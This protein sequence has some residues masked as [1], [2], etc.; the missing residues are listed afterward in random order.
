M[1]DAGRLENET[2][3]EGAL[4]QGAQHR[5]LPAAN[6]FS[7][8]IVKLHDLLQL[9]ADTPSDRN[10]QAEQIR[11]A[12]FANKVEKRTDPAGRLKQQLQ[13]SRNVLI[14]VENYLLYDKDTAILTSF[15][16]ELLATT[17][18]AARNAAFARHILTQLHGLEVL[19]IIHAMQRADKAV[20]KASLAEELNRHDFVTTL[21]GPIP[22]NTVNHLRMIAWLREANVVSAKGYV[23]DESV[24][25]TL[26][27]SAIADLEDA[28][29]L[30]DPQKVFLQVIRRDFDVNGAR[31]MFVR[32]V[33]TLCKATAPTLFARTDNLKRAVVEPLVQGRWLGHLTKS[34][35]GRG[36]DSGRVHPLE[37]LQTVAPEYLG[38]GSIAG[39]P[40]EV[41]SRLN[42]PLA[43]IFEE[44]DSLNTGV[45]GLALE[46]LA[47]RLLYEVGLT[48]IAFRERGA[49][50]DGA[51]V[52]LI[53]EGVDLHFHRWMVQCKNTK[54]VSV[55]ALAK[56]VGMAVLYRAQVVLIVTTGRFTATVH[57][58]AKNLAETN[59]LQAVLIDG[60][61]LADYRKR[62]ALGL[63]P[64]FHR[65]AE[66]TRDWKRPQ[67]RDDRTAAAP[68][69]SAG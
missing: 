39:I 8:G 62:G 12:Y 58:H 33:L 40:A 34:G 53:A 50:N 21:G 5:V 2:P 27:G 22:T 25:K 35:E 54:S 20:D 55:G 15:G 46:T 1:S 65:L 59:S 32:D 69:D 3:G 11:L 56:E 31:D 24:V 36:G 38:I 48:P 13:L 37:R 9:L 64:H 42:K 29:E 19:R 10:A 68:D 63:I 44:L 60:A 45:K 67:L 61:A 7:P 52:D 4:S 41:R 17:D 43:Q 6:D 47:V 57:V 14:G 23:I 18:E 66:K 49:E 28:A 26:V 51:E 30:T 16:Q